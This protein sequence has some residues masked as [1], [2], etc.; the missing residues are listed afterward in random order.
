LG[1]EAFSHFTTSPP[2]DGVITSL[3]LGRV[4]PQREEGF[5]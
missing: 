1:C 2:T 4:E 3:S 5:Q